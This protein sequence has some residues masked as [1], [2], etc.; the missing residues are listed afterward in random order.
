MDVKGVPTF[1][2]SFLYRSFLDYP[3]STPD[4]CWD[5]WWD[6]WITHLVSLANGFP[7]TPF[8]L[9]PE[10]DIW[11]EQE[12]SKSPRAGSFCL[13][14]H[15]T[16]YL[17]NNKEKRGHIFHICLKIPDKYP[18]SLITSSTSYP[19]VEHYI[20]IYRQAQVSATLWQGSLLSS[21]HQH[22]PHFC[23]KPVPVCFFYF[24]FFAFLCCHF[25]KFIFSRIC[26]SVYLVCRMS[27]QCDLLFLYLFDTL[28]YFPLF[29]DRI[30]WHNWCVIF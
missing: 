18:G 5:D 28:F 4:F 8:A 7:V 10:H 2:Y 1:K 16:V 12:F 20:Y 21:V 22:V 23:Q 13:T 15:C 26:C 14:V 19:V 3:I 6:P 27:T 29:V 9:F 11:K 25:L 24:F 17:A 30:Q